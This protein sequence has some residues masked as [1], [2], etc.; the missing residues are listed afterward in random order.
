MADGNKT[1]DFLA[2]V[3]PTSA[4]SSTHSLQVSPD[5]NR[6]ND[7]AAA[8][9]PTIGCGRRSS[10]LNLNMDPMKLKRILSNRKYADKARRKRSQYINDMERKAKSLE[11]IV[12]MLSHQVG[13]YQKQHEMLLKEQESLKRKISNYPSNTYHKEA[14]IEQNRVIL[15]KLQL[16]LDKQ[17]EITQR[18]AL[19]KGKLIT[20]GDTNNPALRG[21]N[22]G[23][24][25]SQLSKIE[26]KQ[27]KKEEGHTW[28]PTPWVPK[29]VP[30]P[31]LGMDRQSKPELKANSRSKDPL[32]LSLS[33][34]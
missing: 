6:K 28:M 23:E 2:M 34:N 5:S 20:Y 25:T 32:S 33:I 8:R 4:S 1:I 11:A 16:I 30:A 31:T 10:P 9:K 7:E 13:L 3:D 15:R 12:G 17:I 21:K 18:Q 14:E 29:M 26:A 27:G 24:V 22:T 19:D